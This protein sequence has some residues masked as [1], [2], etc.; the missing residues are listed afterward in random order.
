M[1]CKF[2]KEKITIEQEDYP[3]KRYDCN[4]CKATF[5][6][7]SKDLVSYWFYYDEKSKYFGVQFDSYDDG[8]CEFRVFINNT[9]VLSLDILPNITPQ[10]FKE[11]FKTYMVFS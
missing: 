1:N 11:K 8:K 3:C 9:L 7:K 2:C 6:Y 10:N 5:R 4:S